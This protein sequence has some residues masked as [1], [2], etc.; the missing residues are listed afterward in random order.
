M[1]IVSYYIGAVAVGHYAIAV[2]L[3]ELLWNIP[4]SL[5]PAVMFK[6]ASEESD[7]RDRMTAAACRHTVL[8]CGIA[9]V[10]L[11]FLGRPVIGLAF[12]PEYLASVKPLIILLPG[13]ALLSVGSVLAND[14][15]GRGKQVM[16]SFAA[17]VTLV[18]NV[19]LGL[20]FVPLWGTSGAAAAAAFSYAV[21][22][23]VMVVEFLRITG[24][25][26]REVLVPRRRDLSA[27][28]QFASRLLRGRGA[29]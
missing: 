9:G 21:G 13:T 3:A 8:I 19:A 18:I 27:Y 25:N 7:S 5:A 17:F 4:S 15:V 10:V 22:T 12:G 23:V 14:F 20:T 26:P 6:S 29:S 28:T 16:N 24:M 11:A 1:F 2:L